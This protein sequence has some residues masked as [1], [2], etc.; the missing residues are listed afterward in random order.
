MDV[1]RTS[2]AFSPKMARRSFFFRRHRALALR[3]DL[4]DQN[5]ARRHFGTDVDDTGFVEVLQR[6]FRYVRNVARDFFGPSLVSRAITSNSS[7]WME[8]NTSS[9]TI[10]SES[11]IESS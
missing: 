4:A 8:V 9:A 6:F 1:S 11:R 7:M 2:E 5:V 3:C 10:R